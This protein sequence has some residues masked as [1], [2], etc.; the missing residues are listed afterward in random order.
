[1]RHLYQNTPD[2]DRSYVSGGL[3][4]NIT[5]LSYQE[6]KKFHRQNYNITKAKVFLYGKFDFYIR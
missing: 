3:P 5:D 2:H 4:S 1:M 6:L